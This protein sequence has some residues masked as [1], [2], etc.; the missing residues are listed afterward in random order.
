MWK[1]KSFIPI[2]LII[3]VF[4]CNN[5]KALLDENKML[6]LKIDSLKRIIERTDLNFHFEEIKPRVILR[7]EKISICKETTIDLII[8]ANKLNNNKGNL[9]NLVYTAKSSNGNIVE[10]INYDNLIKYTPVNYGLD[11]ISVEY[12]FYSND[13]LEYFS[14]PAWYVVDI[15]QN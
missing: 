9:F 15:E 1:L 14:M 10:I 4:G 2:L 7:E 3:L 11:T 8:I 12:Y 13:S 5:D 6:K